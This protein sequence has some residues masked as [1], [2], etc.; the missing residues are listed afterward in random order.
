MS[1]FADAEVE[2]G[3]VVGLGLV[4]ERFPL[5]KAVMVK[6][7]GLVFGVAFFVRVIVGT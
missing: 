5:N 6:A 2:T 7:P 1:E 4:T 3:T